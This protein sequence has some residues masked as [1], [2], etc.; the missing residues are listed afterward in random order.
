MLSDAQEAC[1]AA[2]GP[3]RCRG[4]FD[5]PP[6]QGCIG[7]LARRGRC[8]SIVPLRRAAALPP[9]PLPLLLA[10]RSF[11]ANRGGVPAE[12]MIQLANMVGGGVVV[13]VVLVVLVALV[14]LAPISAVAAVRLPWPAAAAQALL[15]EQ[16]PLLPCL[17]APP[18]CRWAPAPGSACP[19]LL[20][21]TT[22]GSLRRW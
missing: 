14:V 7:A 5:S 19:T 2:Q 4:P 20:M 11:A 21:R 6:F 3:C 16:P 10:H 1:R 15:A 18:E 22:S 13:V 9:L 8:L 17:C 12:Y